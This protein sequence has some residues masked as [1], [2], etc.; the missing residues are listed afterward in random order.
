MPT[1]SAP[2]KAEPAKRAG[3]TEQSTLASTLPDD[4]QDTTNLKPIHIAVGFESCHTSTPWSDRRWD[5][6][7]QG[8]QAQTEHLWWG[9]AEKMASALQ[10]AKSVQWQPNPHVDPAL[11]RLRTLLHGLNPR[12]TVGPRPSPDLFEPVDRHC[13]SFT[14]WWKRTRIA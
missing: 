8:L 3:D 9:S 10:V 6:V 1:C 7:T 12:Q 13:R 4:L 11:T 14:D 2:Y 5:F